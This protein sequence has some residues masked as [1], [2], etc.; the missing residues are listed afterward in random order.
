MECKGNGAFRIPCKDYCLLLKERR[1][2]NKSVTSASMAA[3]NCP[4]EAILE[5]K[6]YEEIIAEEI[7]IVVEKA[8]RNTD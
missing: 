5:V 8:N 2:G 4:P 1:E 6:G 3:N 7:R